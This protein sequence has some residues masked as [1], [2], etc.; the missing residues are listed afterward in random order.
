MRQMELAFWP[1][2]CV[3][4]VCS[5]YLDMKSECIASETHDTDYF[6]RAGWCCEVF[7][8][9]TRAGDVTFRA[10]EE[11][12]RGA[13]GL[14]RDITI[15]K[16]LRY[17]RAA[18]KYAQQ[19]GIVSKDYVIPEVPPWL[20]AGGKRCTDAYTP[21]QFKA[22]RLAIAPGRHRRFADFGMWTGQHTRDLITMTR[23]MLEPDFEWL[24]EL[25]EVLHVGR[26]WR[27]NH[28]NTRAQATWVPMEDELRAVAQDYLRE[29]GAPDGLLI[30]RVNNLRR[31]FHA[32][33]DR[34]E[35]PRI[36]PNLGLRSSHSNM[37]LARGWPYEYVR[38]VLAHEGEVHGE[39]TPD[40]VR[41]ATSKRASTLSRHYLRDNPGEFLGGDRK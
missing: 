21:L 19:R 31:T 26:W 29:P 37:L 28:K 10:F 8:D 11:V 13:R 41:A 15:I 5:D 32:A 30:G 12:A 40:G 14:L 9:L 16:R 36:R 17:W 34:S 25:G 22:F 18:A 20:K 35:L 27:R 24:G 2:G 23:G 3:R 38:Q 6:Y 1:E 7:G 39:V 33:A 4:S